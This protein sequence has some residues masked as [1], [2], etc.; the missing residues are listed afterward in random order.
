MQTIAMDTSMTSVWQEPVI[1]NGM[2]LPAGP[3]CEPEQMRELAYGELL[4]QQAVRLGLLPAVDGATAPELD[5]TAVNVI[6][7]MLETEVVTPEPSEEACRRYYE[8]NRARYVVDQSV[9]LRHILFA[10]TPRVD[11]TALAGRAEEVLLSLTTPETTGSEFSEI[12]KTMSNCPSGQ[13]GGDLGWVTPNDC[14]PELAQW[15]FY[16]PDV[17]IATGVH[18]RLVHTR[19]GLHIVEIL[20][21]N[22]GKQL[23]F[24]EVGSAVKH[25]LHQK[26]RATALKQYMML[27]V[28]QADVQGIEL[29]GADT[30]LV[31]D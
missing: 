21:R 2:S 27:L 14:V 16:L 31:Q 29:E 7:K 30:P 6:D 9:H 10:V 4:R 18:P 3:D 8:A 24:E 25:Q 19:F 28:G 5:E 17:Q 13:K 20:N 1:I 15:L 12:A 26:S 23:S 11:V 22:P